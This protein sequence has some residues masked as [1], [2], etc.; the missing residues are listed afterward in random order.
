M[1]IFICAVNTVK[2]II[3]AQSLTSSTFSHSSGKITTATR[4][5]ISNNQFR[6][7]RYSFSSLAASALTKSIPTRT[8][9]AVPDNKDHIAISSE[10]AESLR[11][12]LI[13]QQNGDD[14]TPDSYDNC[15]HVSPYQYQS[16]VESYAIA[17]QPMKGA[18]TNSKASGGRTNKRQKS[19][20][21]MQPYYIDFCPPPNSKLGKR[22]GKGNSR[23]QGSESLL[24]AVAPS[25]TGEDGIGA[26][27]FDFNAGFGQ[28]SVIM[29]C[30]GA[31]VVHMI[32]RDPIVGLLLNDAMRR[33]KLV[34][35]IDIEQDYLLSNAETILQAREL[36]DRLVLHQC[37]SIEFSKKVRSS[38]SSDE[39]E[40]GETM[41]TDILRPDVCYL[42]P[43]FPPRAKSSAV[44]KNMQILH[45]LFQNQHESEHYERIEEEK[46]LIGEALMLAKKRVVVKRPVAASPLG[47]QKGAKNEGI[48]IPSY[49]L[50]GSV[51]RFDVYVI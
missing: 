24:K 35:S 18:N 17:I 15:I 11:L 14:A 34:S 22:M 32:E 5:K 7:R 19:Q 33:L 12:P 51:N 30:G 26:V 8:C 16:L 6:R 29:A 42:D 48:K 44:K 21:S 9:V 40:I 10:I 13:N 20:T 46:A 25:R 41:S 37:D 28:D 47:I 39:N 23:N 38:S 27:I 31:S 45:G 3:P 43:M 36:C 49:E 4:H 50:K 1:V 2:A